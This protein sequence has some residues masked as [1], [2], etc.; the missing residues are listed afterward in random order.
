MKILRILQE[1]RKTREYSQ[2]GETLQQMSQAYLRQI[3][4]L[5]NMDKIFTKTY[6]SKL[7]VSD[8]S[9]VTRS[10]CTWMWMAPPRTPHSGIPWHLPHPLKPYHP[11]TQPWPGVDMLLHL[12]ANYFSHQRHLGVLSNVFFSR[13]THQV[14]CYSNGSFLENYVKRKP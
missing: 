11:L 1:R 3:L 8:F 5:V 2:A 12:V 4:A 6:I 14:F 7:H 13:M 10:E 9:N